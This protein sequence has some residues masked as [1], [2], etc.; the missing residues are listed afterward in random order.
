V[1]ATGE[2]YVEVG[3]YKNRSELIS[4]KKYKLHEGLNKLKIAVKE[5]PYKLVLDPRC[6]LIDK[7]LDDN[8]FKVGKPSELAKLSRKGAQS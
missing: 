7:N 1:K 2:S 8:E 3:V 5:R 6:L 4:L